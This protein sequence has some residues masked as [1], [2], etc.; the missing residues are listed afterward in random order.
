LAISLSLFLLLSNTLYE[1]DDLNEKS[2]FLQFIPFVAG[3]AV[4]INAYLI[5]RTA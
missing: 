4:I 2:K 3:A 1:E 5:Y